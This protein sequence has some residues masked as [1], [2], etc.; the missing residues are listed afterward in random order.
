MKQGL[1][2]SKTRIT[3]ERPSFQGLLDVA[4]AEEGMDVAPDTLEAA[5][6]EPEATI[7]VAVHARHPVAA[8]GIPK[9]ILFI[10]GS[11][12]LTFRQLIALLIE[13]EGCTL[14]AGVDG[15]LSCQECHALRGGGRAAGNLLERANAELVARLENPG[16]IRE[17][18]VGDFVVVVIELLTVLLTKRREAG[19]M[20][21]VVGHRDD[22][23]VYKQS[24]LLGG[25]RR[26]CG[27]RLLPVT[28]PCFPIV[29]GEVVEPLP[30]TECNLTASHL[31]KG[32]DLQ[33]SQFG[34]ICV[35]VFFHR[36]SFLQ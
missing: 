36:F 31:L 2:G 12:P 28:E 11:I 32:V 21:V 16:W 27:L 33:T 17:V 30:L 26:S 20:D 34:R 9:T 4:E 25:F 13:D 8:A 3:P 19:F 7:R 23:E 15:L 22:A 10:E 35:D 5:K 24:E 14:C 6:A 1:K 18:F 29:R